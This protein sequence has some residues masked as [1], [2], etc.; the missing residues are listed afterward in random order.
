MVPPAFVLVLSSALGGLAFAGPDL[1]LCV[2]LCPGTLIFRLVGVRMQQR[3]KSDRL[4]LSVAV[5]LVLLGLLLMVP[6]VLDNID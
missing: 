6:L 4:L 1:G 3:L 5:L 2:V